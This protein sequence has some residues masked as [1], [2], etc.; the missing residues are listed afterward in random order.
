VEPLQRQRRLLTAAYVVL[1]P[2]WR[3]VD[4]CPSM[5]TLTFLPS[6]FTVRKRLA[7]MSFSSVPR[8]ACR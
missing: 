4:L 5:V 1:A 6:T 7:L 3:T 2:T 8:S